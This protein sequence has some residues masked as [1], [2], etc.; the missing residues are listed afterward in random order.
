M[1]FLEKV[2]TSSPHRRHIMV[3]VIIVVVVGEQW[4]LSGTSIWSDYW[5]GTCLSRLTR[6][7]SPDVYIR[8]LGQTFIS[9]CRFKISDPIL[10]VYIICILSVLR[11][12]AVD[13][14]S[15]DLGRTYV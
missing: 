6:S 3:V 8:K 7:T 5:G 15:L 4:R 2:S 13:I 14:V 1:T 9:G 10:L 11:A 12:D